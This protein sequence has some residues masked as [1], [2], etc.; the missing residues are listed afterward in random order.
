MRASDIKA[1]AYASADVDQAIVTATGMVDKLCHRGS[2]SRGIP[3]F[4]PWTGTISFDWP[5]DQE[6]GSYR[7]WLDGFRLISLTAATSGGTS[8]L[9]NVL[10]EPYASGPP[11][12]RVDLNRAGAS[13]FTYTSGTGQRAVSLTG[14]WGEQDVRQ[15]RATAS[16]IDSS[17]TTLTISGRAEPGEILLID[18]ERMLVA[19]TGWAS[20][21]QT[22]TLTA[23]VNAQTMTVAD[24]S[25]FRVGE[26]LLVDAERLLV[27][28]VVGNTV[29]VKR[30]ADGSTLAAHTGATVYW[31]RSLTVVRGALGTTAASHSNNSVVYVQV[32]PSAIEELTRAY[33]I[34]TF[35]QGGS[36][37]ARTIGSGENERSYSGRGIKDLEDRVYGAY[38]RRYRARAV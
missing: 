25:V 12:N 27:Q 35:F 4:A 9:S 37:Y 24:G 2:L 28:D 19:D 15:Q 17:S 1:S 16:S 14:L 18:S 23:A 10:F 31:P 26:P 13:A 7:L 22:V 30:A 34:D 32:I 36:G 11:Y 6:A 8:I 29:I 38:G 3:G 21:A 20:S 33:A 5:G